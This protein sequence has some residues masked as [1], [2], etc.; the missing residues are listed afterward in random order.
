MRVTTQELKRILRDFNARY[1]ASF[2]AIV[3]RSGAPIAWELPEEMRV[4]NIATL[5]AT[6]LGAAEVIYTAST[7]DRPKRVVVESEG[8]TL[9]ASVVGDKALVVA[10]VRGPA[11]GVIEGLEAATIS[12]RNVL[13]G[14]G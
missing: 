1:K 12:I 3:S 9:I 5:S 10:M 7:T 2:S 14:Q 6:I 13:R 4:D 11:D 8:R